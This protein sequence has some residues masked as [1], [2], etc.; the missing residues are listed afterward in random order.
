[1]SDIGSQKSLILGLWKDSGIVKF[2]STA[3]NGE[4]TTVLRRS[5]GHKDRV[6]RKA[7]QAMADYNMY[8]HGN[9]RA[10]QKR[11]SY[12]IQIKSIKWW[13]TIFNWIFD[14]AAINAHL[15]YLQRFEGQMD[16]KEFMLILCKSLCK[17]ENSENEEFYDEKHLQSQSE[18][19]QHID[20][21]KCQMTGNHFL[22]SV[23]DFSTRFPDK[24]LKKSGDNC[25]VCMLLGL[26]KRA[27]FYCI[28]CEDYFHQNCH[29]TTLRP[30]FSWIKSKKF[31]GNEIFHITS[32]L[33]QYDSLS[34]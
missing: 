28:G 1:M 20:G 7:P 34:I 32:N 2:L 24:G 14:Q 21:L 8:M 33:I 15:L 17:I 31:V 18:V 4:E 29:Y 10:D 6:E 16:R 12:S 19:Y 27:L 26:K 25:M 23:N 3:H 30:R 5:V 13:K 22:G 9:D 11:T